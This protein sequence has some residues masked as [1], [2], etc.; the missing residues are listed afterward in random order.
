MNRDSGLSSGARC[1]GEGLCEFLVWA[2]LAGSVEVHLIEPRESFIPLTKGETGYHHGR[3]EG[4]EPGSLYF[5]R[6]DGE[7]ERPDPASRLQPRGVHG[8]S[9]VM[10]S[11]FSWEDLDWSGLSLDEYILYEIHVGTFTAEGTFDAIVPHLEELLSLGV[12]AVEIMPLAQFP[13]TRNWGY[14]G[15]DLFAVQNSYGGPEGLKRLVNA[16]HRR[17]MAVVLDVVY[18]H[19]GPEGNYLGDF[20]PYFNDRY[21]TPWGPALNFDGPFSDEVR[22]FFIENALYWVEEFHIDALRLDAVHAIMD[23]SVKPFLEELGEAV[24]GRAKELGRRIYLIPESDRNDERLIRPRER[25][26]YGL[27]AV[28]TDDFHHALHSFLTGE[29]TS[30][31][32]DFG[33][34]EP[35]AKAFREGF[36]YTGQYSH[37]RKRRHGSPSRHLAASR[38]VVFSQNHDQV[39]NR[40]LGERLSQLLPFEG[41]KLAAGL[42]L[43]S[44][45]IPLLFMGEEY[46]E[47]APFLYFVSHSDVGL[48]EAVRRGRR[49]EFS[50]FAWRGEPPDPQDE[51]NFLRSKLQHH[52]RSEGRHRAL[53]DFY[54]RLIHL[55]KELPALAHPS[56]DRIEVIPFEKEKALLIRHW[57]ENDEA[58]AVFNFA[59]RQTSIRVQLH[60]GA[61]QKQLDSTE[62]Q[63]EGRGGLLP[64]ILESRGEVTLGLNPLSF[65]VYSK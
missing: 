52:L 61:W 28:W 9:Q 26:G 13:G 39:G 16:C 8:P 17:G 27:D 44:P 19:L 62:E 48:I 56:K 25:G 18:N 49:E 1:L 32:E 43:L 55:R 47:T 57:H 2:P 50:A 41:L 59:R 22:W 53:F 10:D 54:K 12:T 4:V 51:V 29:R 7:K 34:I 60:D 33:G 11:A 14:D 6:L 24:H 20:G 64:N 36:V 65:F 46:G 3:T 63:W 42:L 35:L 45:F 40:A 58:V 30:Y 37:Y 5:Y 38:H 23:L 31:Y 21:L 15:V